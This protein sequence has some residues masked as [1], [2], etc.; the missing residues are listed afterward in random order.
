VFKRCVFYV[1]L[2]EVVLVFQIGLGWAWLIGEFQVPPHKVMLQPA[3]ATSSGVTASSVGGQAG[4]AYTDSVTGMEFVWVPAGCFQMGSNSGGPDEKPVHTVCVDGFW[5]GKYE[6][7]QAQWG[8]LM[9]YNPSSFKKGD[10]FPVED[11]SWNGCQEFIK[12]LNHRSGKTF[13]LPTEAE[14]EYACRSGGKAEKYSGGGDVDRVAWYDF[15]SGGLTH[16]V[17]TK[18]S[19][20]LG[21]YDMSG[22]VWEW[23]SDWYSS[24]YYSISP[25]QNPQG[26]DSGGGHV[27]R[28]GSWND[29][30]GLVR[31]TFRF[32]SGSNFNLGFR[33]VAT[34]Q[35]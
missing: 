6:V 25:V 14:W 2:I 18:T 30:P 35:N 4:Q 31:S 21:L 20:R 33:L 7:T 10:N 12:K 15:N 1:L 22:N 16:V 13:R 19:N 27:F 26:S 23:C 28:G 3:V 29:Y 11:V 32:R 9:D 24:D 8:K 5:I 34:G 17:G